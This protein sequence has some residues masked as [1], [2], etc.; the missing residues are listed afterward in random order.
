MITDGRTAASGGAS[1]ITIS[2]GATA[3]ATLWTAKPSVAMTGS[4]SHVENGGVNGNTMRI[5]IVAA[6]MRGNAARACRAAKRTA[7]AARLPTRD[8]ADL[9][10][11]SPTMRHDATSDMPPRAAR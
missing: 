10:Y 3:V 4:A 2:L 1:V 5:A 8:N 11:S 9:G 6:T 7:T